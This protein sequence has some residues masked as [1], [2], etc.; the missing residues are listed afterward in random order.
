MTAVMRAATRPTGSRALRA[1]L[2]RGGRI[3]DERV[4]PAGEHLTVGPTERSSF[5]V[6]GLK[7][8]LRVLE[9]TRGGYRL[10]LGAGM[11][12]RVAIGGQVAEVS[13]EGSRAPVALDD[14]ARG[15]IVVGDAILLFHFVVPPAAAPR[16]QLPLAVRRSAFDGLDWR[17]TT[18]AAFSFL[19]HFGAVG[20][21]YA[22][23]ADTTVEDDGTRVAQVVGA[24]RDLPQIPVETHPVDDGKSAD[25]S[26]TKDADHATARPTGGRASNPG[27]SHGGGP[28][29]GAERR[30]DARAREIA[31]QLDQEGS[32][33]LLAIGGHNGGAVGRVLEQGEM[34]AGLLD[35]AAGDAGGTRN[36]G[37]AGLNLNGSAGGRIP[38]GAAGRGLTGI[39]DVN[40]DTR[41][42]ETGVTAGPKKVN[43]GT[44]VAPPSVDVGKVP[45]APR[46]VA[47]MRGL[48]RACYRRELDTDPSAKGS[49]RVTAKIGPNGDVVSV[50]AANNGLSSTMVA[51]VSR[52]VRGGQFGQPEG[53]SAMVTIPMT[54]IP[55]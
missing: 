15:K 44:S 21:A 18:I 54:F 55:Q 2:V 39:A 24:L 32:A 40:R 46:V 28:A 37:V 47:G 42:G 49:V 33:M 48:L 36:G 12:G 7:S 3:I 10:H 43:P 26:K 17:T 13:G 45:D 34:P 52:V 51:C 22:D 30:G 20:T 29:A 38:V 14:E 19:F 50:Q 11:S 25:A 41:A 4:F 8:G 53:G 6:A 35:G 9:W 27:P 23:F 16:P 1:A 5:V 31:R